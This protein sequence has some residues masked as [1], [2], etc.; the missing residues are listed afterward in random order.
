MKAPLGNF[1]IAGGNLRIFRHDRV[2]TDA[3]DSVCREIESGAILCLVCKSRRVDKEAR[4][5]SVVPL[6]TRAR[7][8][9]L[10]TLIE[11]DVAFGDHTVRRFV[12]SDLVCL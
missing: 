12:D 3:L 9:L 10:V 2:E 7:D 1:L 4:L 6:G 5:R 8:A 11:Y